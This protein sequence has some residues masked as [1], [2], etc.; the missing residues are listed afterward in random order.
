MSNV[1]TGAWVELK[2]DIETHI[3]LQF[4][5]TI[6]EAIALENGNH[7]YKRIAKR[8]IAKGENVEIRDVF[9]SFYEV[10]NE[11][12]I[13]IAKYSQGKNK[14]QCYN[15]KN[16]VLSDSTVYYNGKGNIFVKESSRTVKLSN[17]RGTVARVDIFANA[18]R[19]AVNG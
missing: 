10:E 5:A 15:G 12:L 19:H 16:G 14:I 4:G 3:G 7:E 11:R 1:I 18:K 17:D 2:T 8:D 9:D 6:T 13:Q